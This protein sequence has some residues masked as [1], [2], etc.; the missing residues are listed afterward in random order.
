MMNAKNNRFKPWTR[1]L[2][3]I[4]LSA[5]LLTAPLALAKPAGDFSF[6]DGDVGSK[7]T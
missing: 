5:I 4:L 6:E 1:T 7:T 2:S 3:F